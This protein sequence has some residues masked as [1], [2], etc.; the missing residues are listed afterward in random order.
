MSD[1]GGRGEQKHNS[2]HYTLVPK[3]ENL[4]NAD[5]PRAERRTSASWCCP[6]I[7]K[8]LPTVEKITVPLPF[9]T[10]IE[11][12]KLPRAIMLDTILANFIKVFKHNK[13]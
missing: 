11:V 6:F 10:N 5:L 3:L 2:E 8:Q 12:V 7:D 4:S 13:L 9:Y 1:G